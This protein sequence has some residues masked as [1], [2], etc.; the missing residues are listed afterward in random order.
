ML[1]KTGVKLELITD[2]K[3]LDIFERSKRGGLTFV[4]SK[5]YCKA[6]N[7]HIMGYDPNTKSTYLLYLDAN[8]LYGW[9]MV[10]ALPYKD[11]KFAN[12]TKLETILN[13]ADDAET[14]YMV[15]V[16]LSFPKSIHKRLKQMPPCPEALV[17]REEWFSE[18]Q[19]RVRK[20]TNSNT[21]CAK[22]VPHFH[23]HL[24][25]CI[26]YRNLKYI[27]ELGVTLGHVHNVIS[28]TQGKFMK[29]YIEGNNELRGKA[30]NEF[31]KDF[32]KLM[33]NSV[34]GKT[35]ENVRN[36]M[37]L[38]LTTDHENAVKWFSKPEFKCNTYAQGLYLIE[39]HKTKIVYDKPVYVGCT[40]LDLSKLHMLKFHYE[41]M[42]KQFGEKA[43]VVYS[44]TDSY[45]YEIEHPNIYEW[46]K[47]NK[48]WFD[49]SKCKRE[50]LRCDEN[51]NVLGKFK[52]ELHGLPMTEMLGL[53]PKSYAFRWQKNART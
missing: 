50:D 30:V 33:N 42:E 53:N 20:D 17:P 24:R 5:R 32:F 45:V 18:Y 13:T 39:T 15:E 6:N 19:K 44:D 4:G 41:V 16:D 10:Q 29:P 9:A 3:I 12:N 46:M 27:K 40:V 31:E 48:T 14:G 28:F 34:F 51:K 1:L 43:K 23:E 25:Y 47:E 2:P 26:H 8:N 11:I 52:D 21:K 36:R 49:L 37:N 35:M 7:Q 38:H 22:L